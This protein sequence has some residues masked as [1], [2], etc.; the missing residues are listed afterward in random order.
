[1]P[2]DKLTRLKL[3]SSQPRV[4]ALRF[5][6]GELLTTGHSVAVDNTNPHRRSGQRWSSSARRTGRSIGG[7]RFRGQ[8]LLAVC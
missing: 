2:I 8:G 5:V 1:M 6:V 3:A 4:F 7:G